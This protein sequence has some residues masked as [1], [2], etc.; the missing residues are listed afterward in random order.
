MVGYVDGSF[1]GVGDEFGGV[2]YVE[3]DGF[4]VRFGGDG[5]SGVDNM[6]F[7]CVREIFVIVFVGESE[8]NVFIIL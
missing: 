7:D 6:S 1:V 5:V 2:I 4:F 8:F 3:D